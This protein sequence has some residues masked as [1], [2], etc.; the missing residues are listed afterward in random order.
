MPWLTIEAAR[1]QILE[2]EYES[3]PERHHQLA[4]IEQYLANIEAY[5]GVEGPTCS[6]K[7][8][9]FIV[10]P[11]L[12]DASLHLNT[13]ARTR[14][15]GSLPS[16]AAVVPGEQSLRNPSALRC[17]LRGCGVS[18]PRG[19]LHRAMAS[20]R[21]KGLMGGSEAAACEHTRHRRILAYVKLR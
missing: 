15:G 4:E 10:S 6:L 5:S 14:S 3:L 20:R 7:A 9:L 18:P 11:S 13:K 21:V 8:N 19:G 2:F 1:A 12:I 16:S 17:N